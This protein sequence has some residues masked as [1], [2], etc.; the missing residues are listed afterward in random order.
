MVK[1]AMEEAADLSVP[2]AVEFGH[3]KNWL[4]AH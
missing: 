4:E 3:G 1:K 2:L